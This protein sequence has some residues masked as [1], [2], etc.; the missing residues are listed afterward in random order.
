MEV[1]EKAI[2]KHGKPASILT[3]R[4]TQFYATDSEEKEK[5]LTEF[6]KRLISLEIGQIPRKGAA[7]PNEW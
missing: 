1:L 4:G 5:G 7:S 2:S 3:D 6:E